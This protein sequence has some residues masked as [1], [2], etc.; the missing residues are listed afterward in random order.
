MTIKSFQP[1][2]ALKKLE[3]C[4]GGRVSLYL[5]QKSFFTHIIITVTVLK[6]KSIG[7]SH[8]KSINY[9]KLN[10]PQPWEL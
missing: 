2:F 6:I 8:L 10:K 4:I 7:Q 1:A 3:I 9:N 5:F